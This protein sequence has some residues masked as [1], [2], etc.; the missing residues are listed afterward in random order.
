MTHILI[1]ESNTPALLAKGKSAASYFVQTFQAI[2][3]EL[4]LSVVSPYAG[5]E[6]SFDG[7]DGAVFTGSGVEWSTD[8]AEAAPLRVVMAQCFDAGRPAWGSCNGLQLAAVVLGG[9]VGA[10]VRG[11]ED[12]LAR[13]VQMNAVGAQHAMMAG[14]TNGYCV[15][16]VHRDEVSGVPEGAEVLAGNGHSAVQ[17][18]VYE[19]EGVS[20][21][22]TQYHPEMSLADV[23]ACSPTK[24]MGEEPDMSARTLEL[25]NW[26]AHVQKA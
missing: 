2:A 7:V 26:L 17:A 22:G 16:C 14:R 1:I 9:G 23:A 20:F 18:M 5:T 12:G 3:P 13:D 24:V 11:R 10:S 4:R 21:W 25:R 6:V 8:A 15:P 19:R